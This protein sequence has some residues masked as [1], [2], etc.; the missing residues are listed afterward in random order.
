[1]G[2]TILIES[3]TTAASVGMGCGTCCG[4]GISAA[5]YGYLTTHARNFRQTLRAF[6][7]FFFGKTLAVILLCSL[8]AILG[9]NII[10]ENGSLFGINLHLIVDAFMILLGI[11]LLIGWRKEHAGRSSAGHSNPHGCGSC[12]HCVSGKQDS[13]LPEPPAANPSKAAL[14]SMGFGYGISPCAP[15]L[16]MMGYAATLPVGF[17][18]V[19][20]GVFAAAS[21]ISPALLLLFLS[22]ILAGKMRKEIPQYLNWFRLA[23]YLLLIILF[24]V[25]LLRDLL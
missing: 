11:R 9:R 2:I 20:G 25:S 23:C 24:A 12:R 6:L 8:A 15:L 5:L 13:P 17:A 4:S 22:G 16:M 19:L 18:A 7:D 10:D 21:T 14:L 1:M 3:L